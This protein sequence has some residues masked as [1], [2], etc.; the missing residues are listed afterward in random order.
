MKI[1]L[2]DKTELEV[3]MARINSWD[4]DF[5]NERTIISLDETLVNAYDVTSLRLL[6]TTDNISDVTI[7]SL[8]NTKHYHFDKLEDILY[9]LND[10]EEKIDI[11]LST[12]LA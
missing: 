11:V 12:R 7:E 6:L 2:K 5:D 9:V 1:I 4:G 10:Y 8:K 3:S